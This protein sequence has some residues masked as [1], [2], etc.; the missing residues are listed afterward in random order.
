MSDAARLVRDAN[1][2]GIVAM[3]GFHMRFHRLVKQAREGIA[4]GE[5][6]EIESIRV[7]WHSPRGDAAIAGWKMARASGG[8]ALVEIAVHHLDLIRFL[9]GS[10][11]DWVHAATK[12]GTRQDETSVL[13]ARMSD[14]VLV[15]GEFSERSPHEIEIVVSGKSGWLRVDCLKFDGLQYRK[16]HEVPGNPSVRFRSLVTF[17]HNL[18][19]GMRTIQGGDYLDS[20]QESWKH[21]IG[22]VE[23]GIPPA[24]TFEDGLRAV[25]AVNAAIDS[26]TA[27]R[28]Q[29]V[30]RESGA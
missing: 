11:F 1:S 16:Y 17:V 5:L 21:F 13:T 25:E 30:R 24:A 8:G 19:T 15:T 7:V 3:T 22:C 9:L 6:G 12:N 23:Q 4:R 27:G 2:T 29:Q 18:S 20:Y 26:V 10:E 28:P 14:G